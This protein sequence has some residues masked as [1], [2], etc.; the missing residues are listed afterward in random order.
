MLLALCAALTLAFVALA[1]AFVDAQSLGWARDLPGWAR[2]FFQTVT[3]FGRSD[4]LLIPTGV[5]G[6]LLLFGEWSRVKRRI[7]AAWAEIGALVGFFFIAVAG[8]GI[9]TDLVKWTLGRSRPNLFAT[10][11]LLTFTP[12]SFDYAHVSFPSG[13]ATTIAAAAV[14]LA[15]IW[16]RLAIP[17]ALVALVIAVSRVAVRAHF[18]SDVIGGVFVGTAFTLALAY[19]FAG[20]GIAF[21][22]DEAGALRPRIAA[23][24]ATLRQPKGV[25]EIAAGLKEALMGRG[26]VGKG[27]KRRAHT[28]PNKD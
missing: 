26:R 5:L 24:R 20:A 21:H 8:A 27:A 7:A 16:R 19:S 12:V 23:T 1:V 22:L 15:L 2:R 11:G 3:R 17:L 4:W 28:D 13:H 10:D 18:P 9:A 25:A 14:A 6:L